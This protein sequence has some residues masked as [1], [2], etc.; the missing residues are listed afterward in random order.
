MIP[1]DN[2]IVDSFANWIYQLNI[3]AM[4][5]FMVFLQFYFWLL[6]EYHGQ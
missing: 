4:T 2:K 1:I 6:L 3:F 5:F